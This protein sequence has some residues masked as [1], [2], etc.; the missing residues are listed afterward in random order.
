MVYSITPLLFAYCIREVLYI[1]CV[2]GLTDTNF[3]HLN[4]WMTS[5]S[6]PTLC[7][8]SL[9]PELYSGRLERSGFGA[10][11]LRRIGAITGLSN[12][13]KRIF[14]TCACPLPWNGIYGEGSISC[15]YSGRPT[16]ACLSVRRR[17]RDPRDGFSWEL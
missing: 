1:S 15:R 8:A 13:Q 12:T 14:H 10:Y 9:C 17:P 2:T 5:G 16:S 3:L 11:A 6:C 7:V 4:F